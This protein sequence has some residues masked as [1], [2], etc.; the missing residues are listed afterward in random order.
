MSM[1]RL[2][3]IA[4]GVP[5]VAPV[6]AF[7]RDFG[8]A[9]TSPGVFATRDGGEQLRLVPSPRRRLLELG[10]G[11]D[12]PD[13]LERIA[14]SLAALGVPVERSGDDRIAARDAASDVQVVVAIAERIAQPPSR[15]ARLNLPGVVRRRNARAD[16]FARAERVAPRKLGHVVVGS[17]DADASRRFLCEGLGF[18]VSDEIPGVGAFLR[19]STDHHNVLVQTA[20]IAFL[21]HTA[22]EVDDVDDVG[23]GAKAMIDADPSRHVWGLGRHYLGSNYFWYLRDPAGNFAEYYSDLDVIDDAA[24]W[25]PEPARGMAGLYSWGPPVPGEFLAPP[26]LVASAA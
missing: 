9:E 4:I 24:L 8:L 7:Y 19:C 20:P 14:R 18:A 25:R 22:W 6:A 3:A 5:D 16:S 2:T 1:H 17:L 11:V 10:V 15:E 21:H 12:H 13:D 23:R 26:D